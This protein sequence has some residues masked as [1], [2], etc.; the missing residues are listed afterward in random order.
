[1]NKKIAKKKST[2]KTKKKAAKKKSTASKTTARKTATKKVAGKKSTPKP[3]T[4]RSAPKEPAAVVT[5]EQ[6]RTRAYEIYRSGRNH[7]NPDADWYDAVRELTLEKAS[8]N[9]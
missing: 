5:P 7:N 1:M 4:T 2:A 3:S 6:I 9:P 8:S